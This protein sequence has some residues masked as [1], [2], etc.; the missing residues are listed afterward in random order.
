MHEIAIMAQNSTSAALVQFRRLVFMGP[1]ALHTI[2]TG[3]EGEDLMHKLLDF[4][5]HADKCHALSVSTSSE[6]RRQQCRDIE[7][8][9]RELARKR[10]RWLGENNLPVAL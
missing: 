5:D 4:I 8:M 3:A 7:G 9:W 6:S 1:A 10:L 2:G